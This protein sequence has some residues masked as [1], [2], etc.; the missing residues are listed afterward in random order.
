MKG[1]IGGTVSQIEAG[2]ELSGSII[3]PHPL[4]F[5]ILKSLS[6]L[7]LPLSVAHTYTHNRDA[8]CAAELPLAATAP[9]ERSSGKKKGKK[10]GASKDPPNVKGIC[11]IPEALK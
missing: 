3:N 9:S 4:L 11:R 2:D 1:K 5:N 6:R 8:T 10:G 7:S